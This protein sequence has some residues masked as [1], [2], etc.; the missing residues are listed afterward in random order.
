MINH[1]TPMEGAVM[2]L[3]TSLILRSVAVAGLVLTAAASTSAN[4]QVVVNGSIGGVIAPGVY[5]RID[6]GGAP[7]PVLVYP[8]PVMI[9]PPPPNVRMAPVYYN[10]PPGHAKKWHKHCH[11]YNACA[12]PVYFVRSPEYHGRYWKEREGRE[13]EY[14]RGHGRGHGHRD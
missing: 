1:Q 9:I 6:I 12:T 2:S 5:G 7:P 13:Y 11:K 4:A 8:Q 3:R 14:E 10:V